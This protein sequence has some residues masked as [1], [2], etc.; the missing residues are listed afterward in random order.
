[1]HVENFY[2]D[3]PIPITPDL[4]ASLMTLKSSRDLPDEPAGLL[5]QTDRPT[6]LIKHCIAYA[7]VEHI[8]Y[9]SG[10]PDSFLPVDFTA[11]PMALMTRSRST[12]GKP[13]EFFLELICCVL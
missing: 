13:G 3:A 7:T 5:S 1:M 10:V 11:L 8:D 4:S 9:E 2:R 12:S 6:L